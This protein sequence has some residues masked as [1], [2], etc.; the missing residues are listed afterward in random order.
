MDRFEEM[1]AFAAVVD[2]GSFVRAAEALRLS[3]TAVSRLV[4]DLEA[5]LGVRLLH[6]TTRKL[7]LT[8][9]GEVFHARCKELLSNVE[10]AEA[11]VTARADEAVGQL[12][13]N[14]PVSF[15]LLH[16]APLW[17]AFMQQHPQVD[18]DVTLSD[19]VVD[20]VDEGYDLAV[21][22]AQLPS[23]SL[24][25]RKLAS[26]RMVLCASPEY[27]RRHGKPAHPSEIAAHTVFAYTLLATGEQWAFEGPEG[28]VSVK[29]APRMRTN[30]GDTCV[31]A[32]LQHQ[33]IVLQPSF[34]V[35]HHLRAGTLVEVLPQYRSRELGIYAVYASR[36]HLTP[37]VRVLIDFLLEAFRIQAWGD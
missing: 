35:G 16:L 17:P 1:R 12:R 19:R 27:L 33:G 11:E 3:K 23:S 22:I 30:S 10:E 15:G 24:V 7:S 6:R 34:M 32:A 13:L 28:P 8:V 36:K 5:R 2:A 37:K 20:L 26:T 29:V 31:A 9:E 4:S 18:L 25:S 14:V 21:R